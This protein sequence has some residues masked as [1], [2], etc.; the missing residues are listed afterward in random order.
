MT[1]IIIPIAKVLIIALATCV[2]FIFRLRK[3][4]DLLHKVLWCSAPDNWYAR[5]YG[6]LSEYIRRLQTSFESLEYEIKTEEEWRFVGVLLSDYQ[7]YIWSL[8]QSESLNKRKDI[9]RLSCDNFFTVSLNWFLDNHVC[10]LRLHDYVLYTEKDRITYANSQCYDSVYILTSY[11]CA[12]HKLIFIV[13][14]RLL[15]LGKTTPED[16]SITRKY[17]DSKEMR[18]WRYN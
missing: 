15:A 13:Q 2:Y 10:D 17:L 18:V 1:D 9:T 8:Y 5:R 3:Q 7:K 11:G 14:S 12:Y 6:S 16:V 4:H